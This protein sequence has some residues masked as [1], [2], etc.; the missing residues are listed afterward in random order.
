[1]DHETDQNPPGFDD[2]ETVPITSNQETEPV[3]AVD[4]YQEQDNF[5]DNAI[6]NKEQQDGDDDH[7]K[8]NDDKS[9]LPSIPL[10]SKGQGL[11]YA[12]IDYPSAGDVWAWRVGRRV[13]ATG[14]HKDRFLILPDRLRT[15][16]AAKSFASKTTLSRYLETNF[17]DLDVNAFFESFT[18]N[19]P[20][21]IQPAERVDAASLFEETSKDENN[22]DDGSS[23]RYSQR[24]RKPMQQT[25]SYEPV[26][27]KPKATQRGSYKRKKEKQVAV[28]TTKQKPSDGSGVDIGKKAYLG[29]AQAGI[30]RDHGGGSSSKDLGYEKRRK[31]Y[32]DGS[33]TGNV[34]FANQ[35]YRCKV[36]GNESK[37]HASLLQNKYKRDMNF[38]GPI[39]VQGK[40]GV[41][42]VMPKKLNKMGVLLQ[43][44]TDG[45]AKQT[46]YGSKVQETGKIRVAIP[47][48][49]T[50]VK[51]EN[52]AKLLPPARIQSNGLK[53][54]TSLT[55]KSKSHDQD[56]EDSDTSGRLQKRA[57]QAH[58]LLHMSSTGREIFLPEAPT[59]QKIR[60]GKIRRGSGTEKQRLRE[61]IRE[62]L[63]EA[64]W[65]I[66]YRP[67]RNRDYLD[68]VYISPRGTAFWSI[69]KAYEALLKQVNSGGKV[70][71]PCEDSSA[72]TLI[73]DE[74][75][76]QLTRK[77][78]KFEIDMKREEQC[79][80]DSDGQATFARNFP[81]IRNVVGNG[82]RHVHKEKRSSYPELSVLIEP[83]SGNTG[84]G[85]AFTAAAK[86]YKL[87][88]T[89]PASMSVERRIILL[90]FGVQLILTDPAKGMNG[91]IAKAEEILAKTPNGYMLQQ[92]NNP[93]NPKIHYETTGPEIWK[94]TGGAGKYLK[95][96]NPDVKLYGVEPIESAILSGGKPG[97]HKIQG[98]GAGFIPSVLDVD[99]IDEVVQVSSDESI[100]TARLLAL[101]EGLLVGISSGAA[102]AAAIKLAK[103]P[104]NAGKLFV[105]VFPSFGER[106]LS[107]VL[108]D[109][110]R[111][112]AE[113]MTFEA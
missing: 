74:I 15:K 39:R 26:E 27:E 4:N 1:M 70:A 2:G 59:P 53:M 47:S 16:N 73:S 24:K 9:Q 92:F 58:K 52:M 17:P 105:A 62:M 104:E 25:Q 42:K 56:S 7:V 95:E 6:F 77:T 84:V 5:W 29:S 69:I 72:I 30:G 101:K 102:A 46:H 109:A 93:A 64:G 28:A 97:P 48:S 68:A 51:T 57:I 80:S 96:Q 94:G 75:L 88:I 20:A 33:G 110:T 66:D 12:P 99:L 34:G 35:G 23:S 21:L 89:M 41:L 54:P 10:F 22:A 32:L 65:T 78:K 113:A 45:E 55:M 11:P 36:S 14:A 100:N 90:A 87:I 43:S 79:A 63:L 106:Y 67:R 103:R 71:K 82:D 98:I 38:D 61:R 18:W 86:G 111:K 108:F 37:T 81:P 3:P 76:S 91:A 8:E 50:T 49:P 112:E 31:P 44:F 83:T 60:D 13:T 40:N 19:I 85:L 107:T